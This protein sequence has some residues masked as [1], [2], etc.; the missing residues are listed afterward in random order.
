M[1][2]CDAIRERFSAF[3]EG[4]LDQPSRAAVHT[5]VEQC[6]SCRTD[7]DLLTAWMGDSSS[8]GVRLVPSDELAEEIATSPCRRWL[9]LLS[10][11]ID[12]EISESNLERLLSHLDTCDACRQAWSDLTL[13]H[14]VSTA[15]EPP[16][17]LAERCASRPSR[18]AAS[19][20]L[21]RRSVAAAAYVL[22][23]SASLLIGNPVLIART[24]PVETLERVTSTISTEAAEAASDGRG[25]LRVMLWRAWRTTSQSAAAVREIVEQAIHGSARSDAESPPS[26]V[27]TI[28][29]NPAPAPEEPLGDRRDQ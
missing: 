10:Q 1:T 12:R 17:G 27:D 13:V 22:A 8:V 19:R 3:V 29:D 23:V 16:S 11:A 18:P 21:G 2:G 5:H 20:V 9:S 26:A 14:Q 25:E 24:P 15:L 6:E 7:L 4:D 28:S